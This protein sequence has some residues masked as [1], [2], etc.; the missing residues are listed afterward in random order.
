MIIDYVIGLIK[1]SCFNILESVHG[2]IM[3]SVHYVFI[4]LLGEICV[5]CSLC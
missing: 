3:E 1:G 5:I 2:I 4:A